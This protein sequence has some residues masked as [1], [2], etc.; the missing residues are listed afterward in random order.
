MSLFRSKSSAALFNETNLPWPVV[1]KRLR[2]AKR[3]T[4]RT[5]TARQEIVVSFPWRTSHA[6]AMRFVHTQQDWLHRQIAQAPTAYRLAIGERVP[7]FGQLRQIVHRDS[8]ARGVQVILTDDTLEVAGNPD[9]VPRAVYRFLKQLAQTEI[10]R[11]TALKVAQLQCPVGTITLRDTSTRW[12]S[13]T[14][15]GDLN[16]CWRLILAPLEVIDYVV[17]H[18]A[19]HLVH[20]HHQPSFWAL[21]RALT[22]HTTFGKN[23]LKIN[24]QNLHVTLA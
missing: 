7:V 14:S 24:G 16:F 4:L 11:L 15:D 10:E 5:N 20:M 6:E 19:A 23:W 8:P 13:C 9:R 3:L 2:Q 17:A 12:G 1:Y 21:C 18:E 22:P